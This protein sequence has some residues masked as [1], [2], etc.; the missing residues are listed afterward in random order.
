MRDGVLVMDVTLPAPK[1]PWGVIEI[2]WHSEDVAFKLQPKS[3]EMT[4]RILKQSRW[5]SVIG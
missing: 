5:R 2:G 1:A 4:E 3:P